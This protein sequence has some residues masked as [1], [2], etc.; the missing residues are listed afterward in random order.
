MNDPEGHCSGHVGLNPSGDTLRSAECASQ[1]SNQGKKEGSI[2][3]P[4]LIFDGQVLTPL[5]FQVGTFRLTGV[6]M[7]VQVPRAFYEVNS[8]REALGQKARDTW[9]KQLKLWAIR[10]HL[11][12]P[13]SHNNGWSRKMGQPAWECLYMARSK[14]QHLA[15]LK[16]WPIGCTINSEP[17]I[18][19][20]QCFTHSRNRCVLGQK[21]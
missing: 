5:H 9:R 15:R 11:H 3:S 19:V 20:W 8:M 10:S 18:N 4:V 13:G 6:R 2:H 12:A 16:F 17:V 7:A 1:F 14:R 21:E